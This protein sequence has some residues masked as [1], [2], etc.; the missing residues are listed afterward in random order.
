MSLAFV[1]RQGDEQ[2]DQQNKGWLREP[3]WA[4]TTDAVCDLTRLHSAGRGKTYYPCP[5]GF[6]AYFT[7]TAPA[8]P[9]KA[10]APRQERVK[11]GPRRD[12]NP[13]YRRE[14]VLTG[15]NG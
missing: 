1:P 3:R 10:S 4:L 15:W 12:L 14:R 13:C 8:F 5:A 7:T 11:T 6:L 2:I 9:P